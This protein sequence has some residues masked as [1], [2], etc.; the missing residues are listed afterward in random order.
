MDPS[1]GI[2]R[3]D[4]ILQELLVLA[5]SQLQILNS[6]EQLFPQE[7]IKE[8]TRRRRSD[9]FPEAGHPVWP[10]LFGAWGQVQKEVIQ[11]F[12]EGVLNPE[13][14]LFDYLKAVDRILSYLMRRSRS[15][16]TRREVS[17]FQPDLL[18]DL[19]GRSDSPR[20]NKDDEET[21]EE[22]ENRGNER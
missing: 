14:A 17:W 1:K 9:E 8:V 3:L 10:D 2:D 13:S 11:L 12:R 18:V 21:P 20:S 16:W 5:R 22:D 7:L 4:P 19:K 6:P 15:R